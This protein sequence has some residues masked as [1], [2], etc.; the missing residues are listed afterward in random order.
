MAKEVRIRVA[1]AKQRDARALE[2]HRHLSIGV[3]GHGPW[4]EPVR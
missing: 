3:S 4:L 2:D 1:E